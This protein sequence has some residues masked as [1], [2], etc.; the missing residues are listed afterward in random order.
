MADYPI[1]DSHIHLY[2]S[3]EVDSLAWATAE[4]PI[5][6]QRSVD[7]YRAATG[8]PSNLKGFI[9]L[10]TDRKHD[11]A[12]GAADGS[13][14]E[15]PL[16]E[17]A[18]LRRIAEGTPREGE[19]HSAADASLCLGIVPW[20]PL[21]S[22]PEVL[23]RYLDRVQEV[24]GPVAWPK[25]RGVRYLLQDKPHGT[26]IEYDFVRSLQ[27]LGRRGL[28]FDL[29]VDQHRRGKQQLED[30]LVMIQLAHKDV[31][32][33]EKVTVI[34]NHLCKPDLT[35]I[36]TADPSFQHWRNAM[37]SLSKCDKTYMKLSG[38]F[39]EMAPSLSSQPPDAIFEALFAWLGIVLATFG[40]R[41]TMFASDWP[42]CTV[43]DGGAVD[44]A[45]WRKWKL[46]I[47]RMCYMATMDPEDQAELFAC[48]AL[49]AYGIELSKD[50]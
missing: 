50:A 2:P 6:A 3:S 17:V 21:P 20:A 19:G 36:N 31:P 41:R 44:G 35:V 9:F 18:W 16:A 46:L 39:A 24:A 5:A 28:T 8:N 49:R 11:L 43:R 10:E 7:E 23:D 26:G 45:S 34:V 48:T 30:A 12:S 15:A 38:G 47:E 22:G 4:N 29:G 27:L 32:D 1:I 37:Y 25:I 40:P 33:D 42:V 13:G 14:W